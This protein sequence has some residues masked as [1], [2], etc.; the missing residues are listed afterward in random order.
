MYLTQFG[1]ALTPLHADDGTIDWT[2][3]FRDLQ[4]AV[5]GQ[6][7]A[8]LC[9]GKLYVGDYSDEDDYYP[10]LTIID[11]ESGEIDKRIPLPSVPK[12]GPILS[13]GTVVPRTKEGFIGL[14]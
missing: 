1:G 8:T 6:T 12:S 10:R 5:T 13:N 7:S 14:R 9:D 4:P 11:A 3:G 2:L